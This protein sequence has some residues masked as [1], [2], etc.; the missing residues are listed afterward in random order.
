MI[1]AGLLEAYESI[2]SRIESITLNGSPLFKDVNIWNDQVASM[3]KGDSYNPPMPAVYVEL[4]QTASK[5]LGLGVSLTDYEVVLHL[6]DNTLTTPGYFD[7]NYNV[8]N[9]RNLLRKYI[10]LYKPNQMGNLQFRSDIQDYN[11]SNLYHYKLTYHTAL[12]DTWGNTQPIVGSVS[13]VN[14]AIGYTNSIAAS[15]VSYDSVSGGTFSGTLI[16]YTTDGGI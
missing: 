14:V 7:R 10:N 5:Q 8:I 2:I 1:E 16:I 15:G 12:V 3:E 13:T 11:H 9:Y 6:L 4:K